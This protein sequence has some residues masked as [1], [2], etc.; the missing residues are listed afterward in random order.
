[1]VKGLTRNSSRPLSFTATLTSID[2]CP[3]PN[4]HPTPVLAQGAETRMAFRFNQESKVYSCLKLHITTTRKTSQ[5][6]VWA[7]RKE[8]G[9]LLIHQNHRHKLLSRLSQFQNRIQYK[10]RRGPATQVKCT[11]LN[12]ASERITRTRLFFFFFFLYGLV[13]RWRTFKRFS[14]FTTAWLILC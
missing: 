3:P 14:V 1:M 8:H 10:R 5:S 2:M 13:T 4:L 12:T 7:S 11:V 6:R 9:T